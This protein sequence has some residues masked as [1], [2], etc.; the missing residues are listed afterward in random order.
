MAVVRQW[1]VVSEFGQDTEVEVEFLLLMRKIVIPGGMSF[2]RDIY[3]DIN[4][5]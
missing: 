1:D 2:S 4:A 3:S 5:S